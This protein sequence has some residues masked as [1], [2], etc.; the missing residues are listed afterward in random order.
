M[1]MISI[2]KTQ[3]EESQSGV[4]NSVIAL[5]EMEASGEISGELLVDQSHP[6]FFDHK[7]DHVPGLLLAEGM[8]QL[9]MR[10]VGTNT[11]IADYFVSH[12][13]LSFTKY[14]FFIPP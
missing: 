1:N 8:L 12:Y 3:R 10:A 5:R 2:E 11:V 14:C 6:F 4:N 7:L 9:A 13:A